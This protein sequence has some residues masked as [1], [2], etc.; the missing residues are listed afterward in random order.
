LH[1]LP[2][3]EGTEQ[4]ETKVLDTGETVSGRDLSEPEDTVL[5]EQLASCFLSAM[6]PAGGSGDSAW[7]PGLVPFTFSVKL[8]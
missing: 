6:A 8:G 1:P 7:V 3:L 4:R 5:G 2:A